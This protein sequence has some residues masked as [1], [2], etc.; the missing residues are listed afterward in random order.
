M[1]IYLA[2]ILAAFATYRLGYMFSQEDGPFDLFVW[3]RSKVLKPQWFAV[4]LRCLYCVSFWTGLLLGS[5][6]V[7]LGYITLYDLLLVWPALSGAA[8]VLDKYWKR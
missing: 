8:V 4:G 6:L 3:Y 5:L 2:V 7:R 1:N